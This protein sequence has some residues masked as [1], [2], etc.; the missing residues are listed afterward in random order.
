MF[1]NEEERA[2][3][4]R[5]R[6]FLQ[7]VW[8]RIILSI[9]P[10]AINGQMKGQWPKKIFNLSAFNCRSEMS[11]SHHRW[12]LLFQLILQFRY[13][14]YVTNQKSKCYI[15]A[16][17]MFHNGHIHK[18]NLH[19]SN[20]YDLDLN[21]NAENIS[22]VFFDKSIITRPY[23]LV[24]IPIFADVDIHHLAIQLPEFQKGQE[25]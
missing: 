5:G 8:P 2:R 21:S 7:D 19:K 20:T 18:I 13:I 11:I 10:L 6:L 24:V 15:T 25:C 22:N 12:F 16:Q 14:Q 17:D 9:F 23:T 3:N 4:K 1:I